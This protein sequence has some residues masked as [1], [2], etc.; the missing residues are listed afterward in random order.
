MP[1]RKGNAMMIELAKWNCRAR[2]G[3]SIIGLALVLSGCGAQAFTET[4]ELLG[5]NASAATTLLGSWNDWSGTVHVKSWACDWSPVSSANSV[6]C[7]IPDPN[8][9]LVGGGAEIEG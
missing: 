2:R 3:A 8:F 7:M 4:D 9:V 1:C 5:Q 6:C